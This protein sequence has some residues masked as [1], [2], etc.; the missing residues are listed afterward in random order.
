MNVLAHALLSPSDPGVLTGN[1]V[2]DWVKGK[3]RFSLP[4]E[5]RAGM[6]LHRRI[7]SFTDTHHL[8]AGVAG[9]LSDKWGR[10]SPVLVD[11][12]FDHLI[13]VDW[14]RHGTG[15]P[16]DV[17]AAECYGAAEGYR[18]CLPER[19]NMALTAMT[20]DNWFCSY[21]TPDGIRLALTRM[22]TRLKHGIELA[23]AVDDF[24]EKRAAF[25]AAFEAFFPQLRRHAE[26]PPVSAGTV[27]P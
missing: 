1:L 25:E 10:Y 18:H 16:L 6:E 7:D 23:P 3:A 14:E 9:L 19:C 24:F 5:V 17:F 27:I 21:A 22:S 26:T 15:R 12:F 13:A 4:A 11:I 20:R 8:V 2:A